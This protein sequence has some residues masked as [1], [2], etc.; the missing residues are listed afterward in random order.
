MEEEKL[1]NHL[2]NNISRRD[3][4]K[5]GLLTMGAG[6]MAL[7]GCS[8]NEEI[9]QND[10]LEIIPKQ[11][12]T[13]EFSAPMLFDF[14][15]IDK[16][17]GYNK[18]FKKS[19][20]TTLYNSIPW[21]QSEKFNEWFMLHRFGVSNPLIKTYADFDRY[22]QYSF[23][24]GF[25]VIYLMNSPKAFNDRDIEGFKKDFYKVL[26]NLWNSGI[27]RIKF[28]NTQ[29]AQLINEYNPN[30]KLSVATIMEY[31]S[32]SQY[33]NLLYFFPNIN[34]ICIPKDLNQ[35]FHFLKAMKDNFP[36]IEIELMVNE[37]C[38]K[39][40]PSRFSCQA[41][42]YSHYYKIGCNIPSQFPALV[43]MKNGAIFPW[44]LEYYSSLRLNNFKILTKGPRAQDKD[45]SDIEDYMQ[46]IEYGINSQFGT[47]FFEMYINEL[48][49]RLDINHLISLLPDI[50]YFIKNGYKCN[51]DCGTKCTYCDNCAKELE[52]IMRV[53]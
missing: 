4:V 12:A 40:C 30:F 19:Q 3:F 6:A 13:Y 47:K 38:P 22:V 7:S 10:E 45:I 34:H 51:I 11:T 52:E 28:A 35:N 15:A 31:S 8:K 53:V 29:V 17:A 9:S 48:A 44:Q 46:M 50:N 32:I 36:D 42:S 5:T 41:S 26:D 33:K 24:K 37:G 14:D 27:R 20:I 49:H 43:R 18:Q 2:K 1:K 23:E 25:D 39:W 16:M 21:P